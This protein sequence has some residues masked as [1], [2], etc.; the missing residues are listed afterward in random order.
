MHYNVS[1]RKQIEKKINLKQYL[2]SGILITSHLKNNTSKYRLYCTG[3]RFFN[4]CSASL[5]A[6]SAAVS[7]KVSKSEEVASFVESCSYIE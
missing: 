1:L 7:P 4:S 3:Y 5:R 6:N 2:L